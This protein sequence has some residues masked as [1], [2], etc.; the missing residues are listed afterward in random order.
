MGSSAT[1][2]CHIAAP[3]QSRDE[4]PAHQTEKLCLAPRRFWF[5]RFVAENAQLRGTL[6]ISATGV[7]FC[8]VFFV[9]L[10]MQCHCE[11]RFLKKKLRCQGCALFSSRGII[12]SCTLHTHTETPL[13]ECIVVT[14][15]I[16]RFISSIR[17]F[18]GPYQVLRPPH[19]ILHSH[20]LLNNNNKA[21]MQQKCPAKISRA[22]NV[23]HACGFETALLRANNR[24]EKCP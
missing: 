17:T 12:H 11:L 3:F 22:S 21:N 18:L 2:R 24:N 10:C 20:H 13:N 8:T 9:G 16:W 14:I 6:H 19:H 15:K 5:T 4:R 1:L 7:A 23:K